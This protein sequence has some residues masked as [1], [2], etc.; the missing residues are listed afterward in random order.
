[1]LAK[2]F[3]LSAEDFSAFVRK[4]P[5]GTR[6]GAFFAVKSYATTSSTA[7]FGVIVSTKVDAR[8]TKRNR[9]KRLAYDFFR[10]AAPTLPVRDY[11]C[12]AQPSAAGK[13]AKEL[14]ADLATLFS[15]KIRN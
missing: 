5:N 6:R 7:R 10:A 3:R 13:D 4:R 8:A 14:R 1:M 11:V 9:V 15:H 2:K 12:I